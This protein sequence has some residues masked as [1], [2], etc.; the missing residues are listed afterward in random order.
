MP[1]GARDETSRLSPIRAQGSTLRDEAATAKS[2][3]RRLLLALFFL[4]QP[5][6][7]CIYGPLI[8]GELPA[9]D[10]GVMDGAGDAS[11]S[12]DA[13]VSPDAGEA[14]D[15]A[16]APDAGIA[17][18]SGPVVVLPMVVDDHF[19]DRSRQEEGR[20]D[21][22][23]ED[24]AC[25]ERAGG[26]AGACHR[27]LWD[28]SNA[29]TGAHWTLGAAF[30]DLTSVAIEPGAS[31][32]R[33]FAWGRAGGEVVEF[34]AGIGDGFGTSFDGAEDRRRVTLSAEPQ[35]FFVAFTALRDATEIQGAFFFTAFADRNPHGLEFFVDDIRWIE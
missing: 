8:D 29:F 14:V 32:V 4:A 16:S 34:G 15:A 31:G 33:F 25:P 1:V 22:H 35:A 2:S 17:P 13:G 27:I 5:S 30:R 12:S 10:G 24:T 9:A 28:A 21:T 11:A 20:L 7:A 19:P 18:D 23:L 26:R 6:T 3:A